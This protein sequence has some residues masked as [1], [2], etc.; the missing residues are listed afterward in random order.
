MPQ[1]VSLLPAG[2]AAPVA[3]SATPAS[4]P[5][6]LLLPPD[7][8]SPKFLAQFKSALKTIANGVTLPAIVVPRTSASAPSGGPSLSTLSEAPVQAGHDKPGEPNMPALL[9]ELGFAL[10]PTSFATPAIGSGIPP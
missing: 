7:P 10:V 1:I 9:A 5:A 2:P 3:T 4:A 6:T 8:R